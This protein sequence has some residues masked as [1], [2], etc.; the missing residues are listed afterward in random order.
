MKISVIGTGYVGLVTG[1]CLTE[2]GHHVT[3]VDIDENKV[4]N[5][6]KGISPIFEPGLEDM[7]TKNINENRLSFTSDY[8]EAMKDKEIVFIAV[9]TPQ[10]KDGS[11][12]LTYLKKACKSIAEHMTDDLIVITKSTVPVGT[13]EY[14]KELIEKHKNASHKVSVVSNP[15]FLREGSAIHDTFYGDRIVIGSEEQEA[16]DRVKEVYSSFTLPILETDLRS[17]E[18]IK[19]ASNAFLATKISF[20]NELGNLCERLGAN[21]ENVSKGMGMDKRI[22]DKFLNAGVGYGG[23]C[24]PKDTNALVSIGHSVGYHMSIVDSVIETND[25]QQRIIIDKIKEFYPDLSHKKVAV[26]GLAFKPNTDDM[27]DAPSIKV[28]RELVDNEA[29]VYAYD[30][31]AEE[32][33]KVF[34]PGGTIYKDSIDET[35]KDKDFAIIMTDWQEIKEYPLEQLKSQLKHPALFDGRNCFNLERVKESGLEYHSIG[36]PSIGV[37][38]DEEK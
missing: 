6:R 22:G 32:N 34:L 3:C 4:Q 24:F 29:E 5:M 8:K 21:I 26:L 16:L 35:L 10:S 28:I 23:S 30:P 31:I 33:A 36:R 14:V 19:Y 18:M 17:A 1:V 38:E 27:R 2:V 15:E 11:A 9:G 37:R 7:M 20:I 13:N 25:K 12:E